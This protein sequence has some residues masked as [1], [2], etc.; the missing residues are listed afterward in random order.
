MRSSQFRR[1]SAKLPVEEPL[2]LLDLEF[3]S[4]NSLEKYLPLGCAVNLNFL[5]SDTASHPETPT[6]HTHIST[7]LLQVFMVV[8][9][10]EYGKT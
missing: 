7:S 10:I 9:Y 6:T 5:W 3:E 1:H 2:L 8:E 4:S